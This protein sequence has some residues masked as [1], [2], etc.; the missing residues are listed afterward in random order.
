MQAALADHTLIAPRG[1]SVL[2]EAI[3]LAVRMPRCVLWLDNAERF[4]GPDGLTRTNVARV[5]GGGGHH[6]IVLATIRSAEMARYTD[7]AHPDA[8][9]AAEDRLVLEQA[10][11]LRLRRPLTVAE[12]ERALTRAWDQ[13]IADAL[14]HADEYGLAEYL[15]AGPELVNDWE[16][17]WEA[18]HPRAAALIA[19]AV[20]CRRA[21]LTRPLPRTLLET[22]HEDYLALRGGELLGPE[23]LEEAWAW[24]TRPRRATTAL[25]RPCADP[26]G[27]PRAVEV[28][29]YLVD[30]TQRD[31]TLGSRVPEQT[32]TGALA[33]SDATEADQIGVIAYEY[34]HYE[35]A[36]QAFERAHGM[37]S[38]NLGPEHPY[39]L[40]NRSNRVVI[41][42]FLA[43]FEEAEAEARAVLEIRT[44]TL[45]L[46]HPDTLVGRANLASALG[47]RG[48]YAQ[49]EAQARTALEAF[50]RVLGPNHISSLATRNNLANVLHQQGRYEEAE[51]EARAAL[52]GRT[53]VLGA[54]HADTLLSH[55]NLGWTL[56]SLGR[57]TEAEVE[58]RVALGG[59]V[60]GL[61]AEHPRTFTTRGLLADVLAGLGRLEEAETEARAA[62]DVKTRALGPE[63]IDVLDSRSE[64]GILLRRLERYEEAAAEHAAVL[65]VHTRLLGPDGSRTLGSRNNRAVALSGM[66]R[67]EEAAAE[68]RH[69]LE[70]RTRLQGPDD[71]WTLRSHANLAVTLAGLGRFEEAEAEARIA[72]EGRIRILGPDHPDTLISRHNLAGILRDQG[73][74]DDADRVG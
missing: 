40:T 36:A 18:G 3:E 13:R 61:G 4:L 42:G 8:A 16:N 11:P 29:D 9:D 59:F 64:L 37:N 73:R 39:T 55:H 51:T 62:L 63:H 24:A 71:E 34:G 46:E 47:K 6:R 7:T 14:D 44:R 30:A 28:F 21:G 45:G 57:Y 43:R 2:P 23:P 35:L 38:A 52:E 66:G 33:E 19:A 10:T 32:L 1:R 68:H 67:L 65:E 50:T 56:N 22:L 72:L 49:A 15:A 54:D 20:D 70:A 74:H 69:V 17:A 58:V 25:I 53:R 5:I 41:L 60:R 12:H 27:E 26:N 31:M 48:D